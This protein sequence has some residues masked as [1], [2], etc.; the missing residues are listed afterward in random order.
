MNNPFSLYSSV[1][2][3]KLFAMDRLVCRDWIEEIRRYIEERA[4]FPVESIHDYITADGLTDYEIGERKA[5]LSVVCQALQ[6][7]DY[8]IFYASAASPGEPASRP[9]AHP[10][11]VP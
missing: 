10:V 2:V 9:E 5:V 1:I 11:S 8:S 4:G 3:T 6:A 7:D